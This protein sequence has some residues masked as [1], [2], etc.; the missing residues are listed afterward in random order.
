MTAVG[1]VLVFFNLIFS[2]VVGALA[3]MTYT[4]RT[5]WASSYADLEKKFKVVQASSLTYKSEADRLAKERQALNQ[6]LADA[7]RKDLALPD[8]ASDADIERAAKAAVSLLRDRNKQVEDLKR[9]VVTARGAMDTD[10][11]T[12]QKYE[13]SSL[14]LQS[15]IQR[16]QDDVKKLQVMYKD[17]LEKN[18]RLVKDMNDLR[19]RAVAAEISAKGLRERNTQL[20]EHLQD[21]ARDIARVR[22]TGGGAPGTGVARRVNPPPDNV[23]GLI[24]TVDRNLVTLTIGG[25]AGLQ[26]GQTLEVFRYSPTPRYI[27]RIRIVDVS[28]HEAVGR[29]EGKTNGQMQRGDTVASSIMGS[30]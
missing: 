12:I 28:A 23:E 15:D 21:L 14:A 29:A 6:G 24:R 20:E 4:A 18:N 22:S 1:K 27:G 3:V 13:A 10:K 25:D 16:R 2:V 7:G 30:R 9:E 19:D 26:R 5:H 11:R 17:E 8:K